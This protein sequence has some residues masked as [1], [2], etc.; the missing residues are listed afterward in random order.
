M[1]RRKV[2]SKETKFGRIIII[3]DC[4][5]VRS[6]PLGDST[7]RPQRPAH[8]QQMDADPATNELIC[9]ELG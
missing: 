7:Q 1:L 8:R 9:D 3:V 4:K 6:K 5:A 2:S